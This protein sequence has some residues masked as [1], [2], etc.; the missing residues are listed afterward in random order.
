MTGCIYKLPDGRCDKPGRYLS[1]CIGEACASQTPS[2]YDRLMS[3]TPEE[4]AHFIRDQIIDRN[5]G[6]PTETWLEWL[7]APAKREDE[8]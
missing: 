7:K 2:N 8:G 4:M 1:P 5:I 3:Y 6:I